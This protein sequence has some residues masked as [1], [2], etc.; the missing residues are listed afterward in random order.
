MSFKRLLAP[1]TGAA[2]DRAA[3]DVGFLLASRFKAQL[4]VLCAAASSTEE[5]AGDAERGTASAEQPRPAK[6][7]GSKAQVLFSECF[8]SAQR[9]MAPITAP[10][11]RLLQVSGT[12]ADWIAENGSLADMIIFALPSA[13]DP[14]W[15]SISV[16][17]AVDETGCPVL[18]VPSGTAQ[19]G[20]TVVIAWNAAVEITR[21]IRFSMPILKASAQTFVVTVSDHDVRPPGSDV[22]DYLRCHGVNAETVLMPVRGSS[23]STTLLQECRSRGADLIVQGAFTRYRTGRPSFGSMTQDMMRQTQIPVLMAH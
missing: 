14:Q 7:Q 1:I 6:F 20:N 4:D 10:S 12:E 13:P 3:L 5:C 11:A 18:L 22:V 17:T 21:A 9:M 19:L 8:E 23:E 2:D 15:P 16:Q